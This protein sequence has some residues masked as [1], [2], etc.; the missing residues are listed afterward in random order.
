MRPSTTLA[1]AFAIIVAALLLPLITFATEASQNPSILGL[2][3]KGEHINETHV[4]LRIE[5][6]YTGSIPITNAELELAKR[7]LE[8]HDLH[9]GDVK[10]ITIIISVDE[11]SKLLQTTFTFRFR[12]MGLYNVEVKRVG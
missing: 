10:S 3:V 6:S 8:L 2:Q 12:I 11:F 1:I 7:I 5:I 9:A 4:L